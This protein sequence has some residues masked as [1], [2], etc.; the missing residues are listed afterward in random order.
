MKILFV[1]TANISRSF[2]A[3]RI[4]KSRLKKKN[5]FDVEVSSAALYDMKESAGDPAAVKILEENGFDGS[6]HQSSLLLEEM[7]DGADKVIVME[8][9]HRKHILEIFPVRENKIYLMKSFSPFFDNMNAD[10]KDCHGKSSYH[11][12][13][14]FAEIYDSI[15]GLM[16]CI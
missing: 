14:C 2:M 11:L 6:G 10:I 1:C 13:L 15:E 3:E 4:L 8:E 12:R 7:I 5:R 9:S 16:K